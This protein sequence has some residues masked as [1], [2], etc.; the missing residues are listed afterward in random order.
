MAHLDPI[1][2]EASYL[3]LIDELHQASSEAGRDGFHRMARVLD[4]CSTS[5]GKQLDGKRDG[6]RR[7][8]E[9]AQRSLEMWRALRAW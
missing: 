6:E 8:L 4:D 9:R 3:A 2:R 7:S 5:L 1:R